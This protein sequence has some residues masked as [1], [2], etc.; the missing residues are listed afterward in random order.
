MKLLSSSHLSI[1]TAIMCSCIIAGCTHIIRPPDETYREYKPH[2]K[3]GLKIGLKITNELRQA[4]WEKSSLMGDTWIIPIGESLVH[5][6]E[7]LASQVFTDVLEVD[8]RVQEQATSINAIL[9]PKLAYINRTIGATSFGQ[10]IISIKMEWE[11]TTNN[12]KPIWIETVSGEAIGST[13][14]TE[15]ETILKNAIEDLF[16]KSLQSMVHSIAIKH[17]AANR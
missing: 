1:F 5:N 3:I 4:K 9:T 11:L 17:F 12:G 6:S 14:W 16:S 15:P 7:T 2:E 13:G 10:S 8:G